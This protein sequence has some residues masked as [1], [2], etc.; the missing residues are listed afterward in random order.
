MGDSSSGSDVISGSAGDELSLECVSNGGNPAPTLKW[1]LRGQ[2]IRTQE[3]QEDTRQTSGRWTSISRL[4]LPVSR[5][6][7][8]ATIYC[9]VFHDAL[10][11]GLGSDISLNI[12]FPPK[13]S[14]KSSS[15]TELA[16]GDSVTLF[17]EAD[18]NPPAT[19]SWRK[20]EKTTKCIGNQPT[21][22]ISSVTKDSAGSYQ[23]VAENELGRSQPETID[24][25]VQCK[26]ATTSTILIVY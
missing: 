8:L 26:L 14:V 21:I 12:F 17:C 24:V 11:D 13:V 4:R 3:V 7:N 10:E 19:V 25:D 9:Q 15:D 6:D 23:C 16:E 22:T 18:S 20:L 2:E 1:M 5:E